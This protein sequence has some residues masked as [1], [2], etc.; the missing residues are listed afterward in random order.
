MILDGI[1]D[2]N[3]ARFSGLADKVIA[4]SKAFLRQHAD[5]TKDLVSTL[6]QMERVRIN[7]SHPDFAECQDI[8]ALIMEIKAEEAAAQAAQ[9]AARMTPSAGA[10][11]GASAV[12]FEEVGGG[13]GDITWTGPIAMEGELQHKESP[14]A[15]GM[16]KKSA[17]VARY[18]TA[19]NRQL[20]WFTDSGMGTECAGSGISMDG[21][22]TKWLEKEGGDACFEARPQ[23]GHALAFRCRDDAAAQKWM[24]VI[25]VGRDQQTW[26][27]YVQATTARAVSIKRTTIS[28]SK[29][30]GGGGRGR[31]GPPPAPGG[32]SRGKSFGRM[33][34]S[35]KDSMVGMS[36]KERIETE[37]IARLL[38][39]YYDII[40]IK[41]QDS[42]PKAIML[43]LVNKVKDEIH[44]ELITTL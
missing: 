44:S 23:S 1:R 26:D 8:G 7:H 30:D 4:T 38:S 31:G 27:V 35:L 11:V 14:K 36:D 32:R 37:V 19:Q 15:G 33:K 10:A 20:R 21:M 43:M 13:G 17:W 16:F 29:A 34:E 28:E 39:S 6:I 40:R 42:V 2:V 3:L 9:P 5:K 24:Q 12:D 41:I 25:Q 18:V 22:T